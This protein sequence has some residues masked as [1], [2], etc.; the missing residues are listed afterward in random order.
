MS[1]AIYTLMIVLTAAG[2]DGTK[3][4]VSIPEGEP[5]LNQ[6]HYE[7]LEK[8]LK[9]IKVLLN[10]IILNNV[11][12]TINTSTSTGEN[13]MNTSNSMGENTMNTSASMEENITSTSAST[14]DMD[15]R[16]DGGFTLSPSEVRNLRLIGF[17][18]GRAH[19]DHGRNLDG[20][21]LNNKKRAEEQEDKYGPRQ[22]FSSST[23][24]RTCLCCQK[25]P[26]PISLMWFEF[27][28]AH[29]AARFA[30]RRTSNDHCTPN[31]WKFV[32]SKD[33]NC[34]PTSTWTELCGNMVDIGWW[35][36]I[37]DG[38]LVSCDVPKYAREPFRCLGI[39]IYTNQKNDGEDCVCLK[40]VQIW[41]TGM[42]PVA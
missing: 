29:T 4:M 30:F 21:T 2:A 40:Q 25:F 8:E 9:E 11:M 41:K 19:W 27:P 33:E 32:G 7:K 20:V 23:T 42:T 1:S 3:V 17:R 12:N 24:E 35:K 18:E 22:A 31:T 34:G 14:V 15:S 6:N 26:S 38:D 36:K 16:F 13:T 37:V 5:C 10:N 28:S 39:R